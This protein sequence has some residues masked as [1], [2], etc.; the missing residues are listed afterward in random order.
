V[1]PSRAIDSSVLAGRLGL[2]AERFTRALDEA[3]VDAEFL[4]RA[5]QEGDPYGAFQALGPRIDR[6]RLDLFLAVAETADLSPAE[7]S[8]SAERM[9]LDLAALV[10]RLRGGSPP[11][12]VPVATGPSPSAAQLAAER[13]AALLKANHRNFVA[14]LLV[15]G[16]TLMLLSLASFTWPHLAAAVLLQALSVVLLLAGLGILLMG[17]RLAALGSPT[18]EAVAEAVKDLPGGTPEAPA[19]AVGRASVEE[20]W[21]HYRSRPSERRI[22][23]H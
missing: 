18:A 12:K 15:F 22:G 23:D 6:S 14:A 3:G 5:A 1:A 2:P 4:A 10:T 7:V 16:S 20:A 9:G 19:S 8:A 17:L 13:A 21:R 11:K